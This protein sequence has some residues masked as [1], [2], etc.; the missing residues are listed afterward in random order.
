M[1]ILMYFGE[2]LIFILDSFC[3]Q[4]DFASLTGNRLIRTQ[5]EVDTTVK[6]KSVAMEAM[7][8]KLLD[9]TLTIPYWLD[10]DTMLNKM[11]TELLAQG[12]GNRIDA[13]NFKDGNRSSY[14]HS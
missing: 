14:L 10:K 5:K 6:L 13:S 12:T 8:N 2:I 11:S 1:G 7:M 4:V 9:P 3:N